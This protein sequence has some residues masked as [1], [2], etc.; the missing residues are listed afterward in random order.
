MILAHTNGRKMKNKG[1]RNY[2]NKIDLRNSKT[3]EKKK[4]EKL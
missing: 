3:R 2:E 1:G 4:N